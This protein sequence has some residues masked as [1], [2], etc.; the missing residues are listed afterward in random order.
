MSEPSPNSPEVLS[1]EILA[2]AGRE[3]AEI[4]RHAREESATLVAAATAEADQ[5]RREKRATAQAG[6]ARRTELVLATVPAETKR[7][8]SEHIEAILQD[9]RAAV[10]QRLLA[11]ADD[12]RQT[13]VKLAIEAIRQ[14]PGTDFTLKISR[15]DHT[16]FGGKL[17]EDIA[18]GV[19]RPALKLSVS[20]EP[21]MHDGGVL[22]QDMNGSRIW[23]NR[24]LSRLERL[25]P[26]LRRQIALQTSLVELGESTEEVADARQRL[27]TLQPPGAFPPRVCDAEAAEGC[28]SP[29]P[30]GGSAVSGKG[31]A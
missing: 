10:R 17:L 3:S 25:W 31:V 13:V 27:A 15:A 23:D 26:E 1:G 12:P 7:L 22:V 6:A 11:K 18:Q 19:A 21:I 30:D 29:K 28:Q 24:L 8:R 20:I 14:M 5:I 16:A 9:V 4:I 2:E